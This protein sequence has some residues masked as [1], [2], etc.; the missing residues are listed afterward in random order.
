MAATTSLQALIFDLDGTAI[1]NS[2]NG[3]PNDTIKN[4]V[5]AA[6]ER[7][8]VACATGREWGIGGEIIQELGLTS[9]CIIAGGSQIVD[10]LS[11][12]PIWQKILSAEKL[13]EIVDRLRE[14]P[15]VMGAAGDP[16]YDKKIADYP[17]FFDKPIVYIVNIPKEES[18]AVID[19][20]K[21]IQGIKVLPVSAWVSDGVDIHITH[22]EASKNFALQEW[23]TLENVD[24][25]HTMVVGDSGNDLPLF[26]C[27]GLKIA[28]GNGTKELKKRADWIAPTQ[29]EDGLAAAI[30]KYIL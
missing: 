11:G 9:P 1:P 23:A 17:Y 13:H 10:P 25:A 5:A 8:K 15:Y 29:E 30:R 19:A 21:P 26:E 18:S 6:R 2:P 12:A 27:A 4:I 3:K 24:L 22:K 28:M 20:L 14:F 16:S 7:V